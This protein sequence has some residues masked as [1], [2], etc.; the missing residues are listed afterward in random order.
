MAN[1]V[2]TEHAFVVEGG[3]RSQW[4]SLTYMLPIIMQRMMQNSRI[5]EQKK[6]SAARLMMEWLK[7]DPDVQRSIALLSPENMPGLQ[8]LEGAGMPVDFNAPGRWAGTSPTDPSQQGRVQFGAPTGEL[9][10]RPTEYPQEP[11][12]ALPI[13]SLSEKEALERTHKQAQITTE[14]QR[15]DTAQIETDIKRAELVTK[16]NENNEMAQW[17]QS[18]SSGI[19]NETGPINTFMGECSK[20]TRFAAGDCVSLAI[21]AVIPARADSEIAQGGHEGTSGDAIYELGKAFSMGP[22]A[23]A[24]KQNAFFNECTMDHGLPIGTCTSLMGITE[25]VFNGTVPITEA[26]AKALDLDP[27]GAAAGLLQTYTRQ[28]IELDAARLRHDTNLFLYKRDQDLGVAAKELQGVIPGMSGVDARMLAKWMRNNR[29][30][31]L[32]DMANTP[33]NPCGEMGYDCGDAIDAINEDLQILGDESFVAKEKRRAQVRWNKVTG[34][35]FAILA[36]N[37]KEISQMC[38]LVTFREDDTPPDKPGGGR[39][40]SDV[41]ANLVVSIVHEHVTKF[42]Q[43]LKDTSPAGAEFS[44]E[45]IGIVDA[46]MGM[47]SQVQHAFGSLTGIAYGSV[48]DRLNENAQRMQP[49]G[50]APLTLDMETPLPEAPPPDP[51]SQRE[52]LER[53]N[54]LMGMP[55]DRMDSATIEALMASNVETATDY[56]SSLEARIGNVTISIDP[57]GDPLSPVAKGLIMKAISDSWEALMSPEEK[58]D[59]RRQMREAAGIEGEGPVE[60]NAEFVDTWSKNSQDVKAPAVPGEPTQKEIAAA[61][62][63]DTPKASP[64]TR[65]EQERTVFD[66]MEKAMNEF[67]NINTP[68]SQQR[69]NELT[70]A[71]TAWVEKEIDYSAFMR[72]IDGGRNQEMIAKPGTMFPGQSRN[73]R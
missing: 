27:T 48:I 37:I 42:A 34:G 58:A 49:P 41:C 62:L 31:Q 69:M 36:D 47:M 15:F 16:E 8:T 50:A 39:Y 57:N 21:R 44:G 10:A 17:L 64:R 32:G 73:F 6:T 45:D 51:V 67:M 40:S 29:G 65:L 55:G 12:Y 43:V 53:A 4:D 63:G 24:M 23:Q 52:A 59:F 38:N 60:I 26:Y 72:I 7:L 5:Q 19:R 33:D 56:P 18:L 68:G 14:A 22:H 30:K 71:Y 54:R 35:D 2:E 46:G 20:F 9:R 1:I 28:R 25:R 13:R 11:G 3:G 70:T 61:V 66:L